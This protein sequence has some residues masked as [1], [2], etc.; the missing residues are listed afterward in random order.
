MKQAD[1]TGV[2][3][4]KDTV[5]WIE[6]ALFVLYEASFYAHFSLDGP[7]IDHDNGSEEESEGHYDDVSSVYLF[8]SLVCGYP[9]PL[10]SSSKCYVSNSIR[11]KPSLKRR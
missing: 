11:R 9:Y 1:S 10:I 3:Q 8:L 4:A 2:R 5:G 7:K 6:K